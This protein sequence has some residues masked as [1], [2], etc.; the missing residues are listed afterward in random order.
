[1]I[2]IRVYDDEFVN[3]QTVDLYEDEPIKYNLSFAEIQDITRKNSNF[4]QNFDLPGTPKNNRVF[5]HFYDSSVVNET[6]DTR[7]KH[8][9]SIMYNGYELASGYIRFQKV[10][11]KTDEVIYTVIFYNEVGNLISKMGDKKLN[12][13]TTNGSTGNL[14]LDHDMTQENIIQSWNVNSGNG[15]GLVNGSILY[16]FLNRG[17]RYNLID[18]AYFISTEATPLFDLSGLKTTPPNPFPVVSSITYND[19]LKNNAIQNNMDLEYFSPSVRLKDLFELILNDNGFQMESEFFSNTDFVN[20]IYLPTTY[21]T[22]DLGLVQE[23]NINWAVQEDSFNGPGGGGWHTFTYDTLLQDNY[24]QWDTTSTFRMPVSGYYNFQVEFEVE[25]LSSTQKDFGVEINDPLSN[26]PKPF[27]TAEIA[28]NETKTFKI[29]RWID[30]IFNG[31]NNL[32]LLRL[33]G[34]AMSLTT[35]RFRDFRFRLLNSPRLQ[36]LNPLV[37]MDQQLGDTLSQVDVVSSVLKQFNLVMIP[38]PNEERVL[39]VEPIQSWVGSGEVIDW[40][41]KVNRDSP[42]SLTDTTKF[43]NSNIE[44]KPELGKDFLS[45]R[46][47]EENDF[48]FGKREVNLN[49]DYKQST[50]KIESKFT[51]SQ[52]ELITPSFDYTAPVFFQAKDVSVGESNQRVSTNFQSTPTLIYWCG[53]RNLYIDKG[54]Y[55]NFANYVLGTKQHTKVYPQSHHLTYYPVNTITQNKTISFNKDQEQGLYKQLDINSDLYNLFYETNINDYVDFDSRFMTCELYLT[56]TDIKA[57]DFSEQ[58]TI[59]NSRWRINKLKGID[60]RKP[61]LV[62][63]EFIKL[64]DDPIVP[65]YDLTDA[66][67]LTRCDGSSSLYTTIELNSNLLT[68]TNRVIDIQGLCYYVNNPSPF[69]NNQT[70]TIVPLNNPTVYVGCSDCGESGGI[71]CE[72]VTDIT[73]SFGNAP[74]GSIFLG[75]FVRQDGY[76]QFADC[77]I[78]QFYWNCDTQQFI[79]DETT[80]SGSCMPGTLGWNSVFGV[81]TTIPSPVNRPGRVVEDECY[82]ASNNFN[83]DIYWEVDDSN[84]YPQPLLHKICS[85]VQPPPPP[86]CTRYY[87][88]FLAFAFIDYEDCNG[89]TQRIFGSNPSLGQWSTNNFCARSIITISGTVT[90]MSS[91][92]CDIVTTTTTIPVTTTTTTSNVT[93]TTTTLPSGLCLAYNIIPPMTS[94]E[95]LSFWYVDCNGV[96]RFEEVF[97]T[98]SGYTLCMIMGS[99]DIVDPGDW[100]SDVIPLGPCNV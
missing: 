82:S 86:P 27:F 28:G 14:R 26:N 32:F 31:N 95:I 53:L 2:Q 15:T 33:A 73:P 13:L 59:D 45:K 49:T 48:E 6:F 90:L 41:T 68:F 93:T 74:A 34:A 78:S 29:S 12:D 8:N 9:A 80:G 24:N 10:T 22:P 36:K 98:Q 92:E 65:L 60:L 71:F 38:K 94:G 4:T 100:R 46:Y 35:L 52:E 57:L 99:L 1:M 58:I 75:E 63:G 16:P 17:Y 40:T 25:N 67:I 47:K 23:P 76:G 85:T 66:L 97:W 37:F 89:D 87:Y 69:D 54:V 11:K 56:D 51:V 64:Q 3:Y 79:V 21:S 39:I 7:V 81:P 5:N 70:Y 62:K 42:I 50:T 44:F 91:E 96:L 30:T 61:N 88:N 55:F 19:D 20:N 72:P 43:I 84:G 83:Y 77:E 18:D